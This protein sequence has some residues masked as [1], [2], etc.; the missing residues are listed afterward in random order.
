MIEVLGG[1]H[2]GDTGPY[3]V[4]RHP[5]Y[6]ATLLPFLTPPARRSGTASKA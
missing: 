3:S 1:K 4:V 5:K 6:S 2:M